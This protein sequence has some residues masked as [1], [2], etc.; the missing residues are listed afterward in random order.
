MTG[1]KLRTTSAVALAALLC[2]CGATP[3]DHRDGQISGGS[4]GGYA[5]VATCY[6]PPPFDSNPAQY[7]QNP[8]HAIAAPDTHVVDTQF[9]SPLWATFTDG[10][11][12]TCV[13]TDAPND[14]DECVLRERAVKQ[15]TDSQKAI[16]NVKPNIR[17]HLKSL[18]GLLNVDVSADG[19]TY[20]FLGFVVK[21]NEKMFAPAN[22]DSDCFAKVTTHASGISADLYLDRCLTT[23]RAKE[24]SHLKLTQNVTKPGYAKI[25]AIEALTF[26]QRVK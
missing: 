7:K 19:K 18:S 14:A 22:T 23:G 10:V 11:A 25:D 5:S 26:R 15:Y 9:C 21:D 20:S 24:V 16:D 13:A 8:N 3:P 12:V 6:L 1:F 4:T 17:L 2:G